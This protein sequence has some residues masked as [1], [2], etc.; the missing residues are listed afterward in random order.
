MIEDFQSSLIVIYQ[1]VQAPKLITLE[2]LKLDKGFIY[3][4]QSSKMVF[5][6]LTS[7]TGSWP[8]S[9]T[10]F[11]GN[12]RPLCLHQRLRINNQLTIL[13]GIPIGDIIFWFPEGL[14]PPGN[15]DVSLWEQSYDSIRKLKVVFW[16]RK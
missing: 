15:W 6:S 8:T 10:A 9:W 13:V 14:Q 2:G 1:E 3:L 11:K 16:S 5:D 4:L 7:N 12:T